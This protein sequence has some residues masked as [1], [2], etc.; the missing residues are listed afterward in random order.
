MV[1]KITR[2][3]SPIDDFNR[4]YKRSYHFFLNELFRSIDYGGLIVELMRAAENMND[5][6]RIMD[7]LDCPKNLTEQD[8]RNTG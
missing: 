6:R 7:A 8:E 5:L 2:K 1:R 3:S 4:I